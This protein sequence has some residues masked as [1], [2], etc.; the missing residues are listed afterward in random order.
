MN[1]ESTSM[2]WPTLGLRTVKEQ[3]RTEQNS[4]PYEVIEVDQCNA[5]QTDMRA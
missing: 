2:M 1:G 4:R 3:N 5:S